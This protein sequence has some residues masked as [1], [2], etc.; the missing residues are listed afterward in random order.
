M[1]L[2]LFGDQETVSIFSEQRTVQAWLDVEVA[3]AL[4][5]AEL[6]VIPVEAAE[7]IREAATLDNVDLELLWSEAR[8]VGYPILPLLRQL[9]TRMPDNHRGRIHEGATTQDVMD[10]GLSLQLQAA[11]RR[12]DE[13]LTRLGNRLADLAQQHS[14]TLIV[15]RTHSQ[16]AV[17][18]VL[19]VKFGVYLAEVTRQRRRLAAAAGDVST[20]SLFG[21][22]GSSAAYGIEAPQIR[23]GVAERLGLHSVDVPWHV[24]R[25]S[26]TAFSSDCASSAA[27][28]ARFAREV[29]ALSRTEIAELS[30]AGGH[31]RGASSTMPQKRNPI[32]SEAIIGLSVSAEALNVAMYRAMEAGHERAAGE[33]QVEWQALTQIVCL[34]SS[35]LMMAA[36]VAEDLQVFPE[37]ML[38]NL[39][40][41]GDLLLSEAYMMRLVEPLGRAGAHALVYEAVAEARRTGDTLFA[42][43]RRTSPD[44][45]Q[46]Y[47][48]R[49]QRPE[50]Y[51][52]DPSVAI[53]AAVADW[54]R[55]SEAGRGQ[56]QTSD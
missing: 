56:G 23:R 44:S 27:T 38:A 55:S 54:E 34:A 5:Q 16:H 48:T 39:S 51:I 33:W 3:L 10:T 40:R 43:L 21:A 9:E 14:E 17:P 30:E 45:V 1:L 8:T 12:Q 49:E 32:E 52:G 6:G 46:P 41:E 22:G 7:A 19:G 42:V 20:V 15:A 25:D 28:C 47:L 36:G 50:D 2:E 37:H 24:A 29:I 53:L 35:S 18:T 13:L 11:H 31:L 26:L 4:T